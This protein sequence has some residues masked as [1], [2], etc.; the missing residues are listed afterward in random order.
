MNR[1][2]TYDDERSNFQERL[3]L[4]RQQRQSIVFLLAGLTDPRNI[5]SLFR[6]ADAA[7]IEKILFYNCSIAPHD[8][9]INK[10]ARS[11]QKY[12]TAEKLNSI[13]EVIDLKEAYQLVA[14]EITSDSIPYTD[15]KIEKPI[16]IIIGAE[17]T[18][19][20][21]NILNIVDDTIHIPMYGI[22]TSMNVSVASGIVTYHFL[23]QILNI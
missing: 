10:T 8:K 17:N 22:N 14:L 1:Q 2:L 20:V 4:I 16:C 12:V 23:N 18:G 21:K 13:Q 6:L 7:N 9:R 11:T 19:V 3:A 5:G 15:L